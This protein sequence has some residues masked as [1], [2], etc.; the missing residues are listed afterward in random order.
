[1]AT[2]NDVLGAE[3]SGELVPA[4]GREWLVTPP[5][6]ATKAAF[7]AWMNLEARRRLLSRK[8]HLSARDYRAEWEQLTAAELRDAFAWGGNLFFDV[9]ASAKGGLRMTWLLLRQR[10]ED[11][12]PE[13]VEEV[14]ADAGELLTW[15]VQA[16]LHKGEPGLFTAPGPGPGKPAAAPATAE[17][18]AAS[19]PAATPSAP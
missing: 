19:A 18:A 5:T 11:V 12:T 1:M 8:P 7:E 16:A 3:G 14:L 10:Q 15:A 2:I 4:L 13:L 6:L 9:I 17:G